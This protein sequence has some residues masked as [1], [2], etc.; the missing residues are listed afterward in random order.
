MAS[1]GQAL[2]IH[3]TY[4]STKS[5]SRATVECCRYGKCRYTHALTIAQPEIPRLGWWTWHSIVNK[6]TEIV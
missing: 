1:P 2:T 3:A 5:T 6:H 4:S